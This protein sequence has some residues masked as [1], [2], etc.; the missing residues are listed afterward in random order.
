VVADAQHTSLPDVGL[1]A[2]QLG[3]DFGATLPAARTSR[4]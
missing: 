2:E 1:L 3:L 4:C